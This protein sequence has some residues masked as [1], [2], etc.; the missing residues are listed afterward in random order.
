MHVAD[1]ALNAF[2]LRSGYEAADR[3]PGSNVED[4]N[5]EKTL[6][7][8]RTEC[9]YGKFNFDLFKQSKP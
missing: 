9:L 2:F 4:E 7:A 6:Q 5:N 8:R 1:C 3:F